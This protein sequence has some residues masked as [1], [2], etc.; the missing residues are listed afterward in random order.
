MDEYNNDVNKETIDVIE[1]PL[2]CAEGIK[3]DVLTWSMTNKA[4][5]HILSKLEKDILSIPVITVALESTFSAEKRIIDPQRASTKTK[6]VEMLFSG[7]DWVKEMYD[8]KKG[9][10]QSIVSIT[11]CYLLAVSASRALA[12]GQS[13]PGVSQGGGVGAPRS[14]SPS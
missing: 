7:G 8:L 2:K 9:S 10:S 13:G 5:Y 3:F 1:V 12:D 4:K 11:K 6:T 14:S